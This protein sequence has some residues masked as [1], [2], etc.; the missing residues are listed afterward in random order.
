M[1]VCEE[2]RVRRGVLVGGV[3]ECVLEVRVCMIK[4]VRGCYN[5]LEGVGVCDRACYD[6]A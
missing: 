4:C 3:R 5:V 1:S 2:G 6:G